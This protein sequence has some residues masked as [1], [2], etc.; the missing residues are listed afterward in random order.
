[1]DDAN[2]RLRAIAVATKG[3]LQA[4]NGAQAMSLL[5]SSERVFTD[6]HDW[7]RYGEPEQVGQPT[8]RPS[9]SHNVRGKKTTSLRASAYRASASLAPPLSVSSVPAR[10]VLDPEDQGLTVHQWTEHHSARWQDRFRLRPSV[11]GR[12]REAGSADGWCGR[13]PPHRWL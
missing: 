4:T 9:T 11:A 7:I 2:T 8:I 13:R 6:C 3:I 5:L 1:V 10:S 12:C